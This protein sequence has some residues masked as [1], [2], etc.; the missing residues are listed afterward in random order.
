MNE[1]SILDDAVTQANLRVRVMQALD[2]SD[3]MPIENAIY[4]F[5]W[6][7][8]NFHDSLQAGYAGWVVQDRRCGGPRMAPV[9]AYAMVMH[10]LDEAHLMNLSVA[11]EHQRRGLGRWLLEWLSESSS[12]RGAVG[13]FLEVRPSNLSALALYD[14]V[15]FQR[16]GLRRRYYPNG[17]DGRED[18]I[19]MR[20]AL[21]NALSTGTDL[22]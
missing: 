11:T 18:A 17:V 10:V 5:P 3:I 20:N 4:P 8:G 22:A 15:G 1:G 19:V 12:K 2:V 14:Q 9:I 6:T 21:S 7:A 13:M 16:I